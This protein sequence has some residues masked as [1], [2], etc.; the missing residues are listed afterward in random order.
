MKKGLLFSVFITMTLCGHAQTDRVATLQ[1]A[2]NLVVNTTD[3][4]SDCYLVTASQSLMIHKREG[5]L[6]FG[7]K[8]LRP[9]SIA[10][11]RLGIPQ[12]FSFDEDST[13]FTPR[14]VNHGL[15]AFRS[16]LSV[17]KWNTLAL[18]VSLT[19]RQVADAFG[20]DALLADVKDIVEDETM[21]QFNFKTI[22]LNT[23]EVVIE[24]NM[25]YLIRPTREPD[26]AIGKT[27]SVAYGDKKISGPVYL[28]A[29]VS[30]QK[31]KD[32]P[33]YTLLYSN[34]KNL[35]FRFHGTYTM[36]EIP[37]S[38]THPIYS[39]TD[40]GVFAQTTEAVS[41][42]AFHGWLQEVLN[43]DGKPL[44]F[45][46]DGIG[47]S[48][49]VTDISFTLSNIPFSSKAIYTLDGRQVT[50]N[51]RSGLYIINGKKVFVK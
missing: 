29:D 43:S 50:G 36:R 41:V 16:T 2:R 25:V 24:P 49:D 5:R 11:M 21:A 37:N 4:Q 30:M 27:T 34:Q 33:G 39:L 23:D 44:Q 8:S 48:E 3:G 13:V 12:K 9:D 47:M 20:E 14:E 15:L 7:N 32:N 42:P 17:G 18:P 45:F 35:R 38:S 31:G 28:I 10:G 46:V 19:G 1:G 26:I 6:V 22:S 40:D 51:P